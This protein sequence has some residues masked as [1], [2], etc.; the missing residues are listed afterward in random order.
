M[1]II[2]IVFH[3]T[4]SNLRETLTEII[5]FNK[6]DSIICFISI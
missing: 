5:V 3:H 4:E 2:S 1:D 6:K